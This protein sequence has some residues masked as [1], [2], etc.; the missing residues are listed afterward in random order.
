[1]WLRGVH[2]T[3]SFVYYASSSTVKD[4][5]RGRLMYDPHLLVDRFQEFDLLLQRL[6][7]VLGVDVSQ[8]LRV[9]ILEHRNKVGELNR[10][11]ELAIWNKASWIGRNEWRN[12][13]TS[14]SSHITT[15]VPKTGGTE[16]QT[17]IY[18]PYSHYWLYRILFLENIIR[19]HIIRIADI[20][21]GCSSVHADDS[22]STC[23]SRTWYQLAQSCMIPS[24]T[25]V[26]ALK[27]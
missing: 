10:R 6:A 8:S 13:W 16:G 2:V 14:S 21:T 5:D 26:W 25:Y 4:S 17:Y 7:S 19:I 1:M 9:K 11:I 22:R 15:K 24:Y 20:N 18:I 23:H 3:G 27:T 12:I